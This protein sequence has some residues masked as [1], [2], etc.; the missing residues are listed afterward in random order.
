MCRSVYFLG[1]RI[2]AMRPTTIARQI[3][4]Q[5]MHTSVLHT[6]IMCSANFIALDQLAVLTQAPAAHYHSHDQRGNHFYT[7]IV[8]RQKSLYCI[9]FSAVCFKCDVPM[10]L[11]LCI[12]GLFWVHMF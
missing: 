6:G 4:L 10:C 1:R 11:G 7:T 5:T 12:L 2:N 9:K 8:S 3:L